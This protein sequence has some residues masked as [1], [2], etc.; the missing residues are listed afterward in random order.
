MKPSQ[1][2]GV[3]VRCVGL[4][5]VLAAAQHFFTGLLLLVEPNSRSNV[6]PA[7]HLFLYGVVLLVIGWYLLRGAPYIV[8]FAYPH[9]D[10]DAKDDS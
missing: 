3:F 4:I 7:S 5:L 2:F 6:S 8:N 9:A 10:S 1:A